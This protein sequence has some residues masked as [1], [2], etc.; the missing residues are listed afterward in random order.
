M[1]N[2]R[3]VP[4]LQGLQ[5]LVEVSD[6][7][8]F[9]QAAQ[10]LCLTQSAVSRKIQ[11]LE[12]HFGVPMFVRTSRSLRLTAEGEQV[13]TS[14]RSILAQLKV[15]EDRLSPHKRPF[16]IRLHV[17]LAVRWLLPKLSDF[18]RRHPDVS[19]AIETVATEVVEPASDSDAYI[20]YLP[21]PAHDPGSLSLF[22]EALVPVCAPGLGPLAS[23][24]DLVRF[25]LLHRSAD[26]QDWMTWLAANGARSLE[27][28][29]H[30]PFNLDELALD[31]AAR[32]LG[33]AMTDMTLAAESIER[34]VLVVP[35]GRPLQTGGVYSLCLQPSAAS[36]PA[37]SVVMQ[38]FARQT[39][40]NVSSPC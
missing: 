21:Q 3:H 38:W 33:V 17:S 7:A 31:A 4:S 35:F 37:C 15:L 24:E 9:T 30:I 27:A 34:G 22:Q 25:A 11:Q 36:H 14:A 1:G 19:L 23:V 10:K 12:S 26:K 5:A 20:R 6:C 18:Y 13:L 29:R 39:Q 32:G 8:S 40:H 28:Y 2:I 16:R